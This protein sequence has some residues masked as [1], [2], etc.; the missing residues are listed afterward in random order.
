MISKFQVI[1][2]SIGCCMVKLNNW[3]IHE[4]F[5]LKSGVKLKNNRPK[6]DNKENS[7]ILSCFVD[8][9]RLYLMIAIYLGKISR[10]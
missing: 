7:S 4:I 8:I 6:Q 2:N 10:C 3:I 1:V 5:K 9:K